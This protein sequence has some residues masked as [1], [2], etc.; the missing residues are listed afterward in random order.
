MIDTIVLSLT[1]EIYQINEPDKFK[2][3]AHWTLQAYNNKEA[4]LRYRSIISKQNATKKELLKGIYKP[5]LT[6]AYCRNI[7]GTVEP[8][9]KIE[10]SLPK[11][12]MV[13]I[14]MSSNTKILKP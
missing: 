12:F 10:L 3:A 8:L 5:H 6:L 4:H 9:L 14:L 1:S 7:Q 11:L 2:P 13:I